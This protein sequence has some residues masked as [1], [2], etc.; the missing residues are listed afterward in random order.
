MTRHGGRHR[1]LA[2][3]AS[4]RERPSGRP[5]RARRPAENAAGAFTTAGVTEPTAALARLRLYAALERG[6]GARNFSA[7]D[8]GHLGA[9]SDDPDTVVVQAEDDVSTRRQR[10]VQVGAHSD[11]DRLIPALYGR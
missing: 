3:T 2:C 11:R 6:C 10:S 7:H 8:I 4:S 1:T 5:Q 9:D